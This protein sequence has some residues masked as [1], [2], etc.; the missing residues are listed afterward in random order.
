M[1]ASRA[2]TSPGFPWSRRV[3]DV[4]MGT[5]LAVM[6]GAEP[7]WPVIG[8]VGPAALS[9]SGSDIAS[10]ISEFC[11]SVAGHVTD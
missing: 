11:L 4:K 1:S 5:P 10:L 3:G 2:E 6:P 8:L 7:F 9:M